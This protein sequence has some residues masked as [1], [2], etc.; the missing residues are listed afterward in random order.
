[1]ALIQNPDWPV[2]RWLK[3]GPWLALVLAGASYALIAES[4]SMLLE[5]EPA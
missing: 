4:L 1:M 3:R 5:E 2:W